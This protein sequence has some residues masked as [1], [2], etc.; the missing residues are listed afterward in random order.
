MCACCCICGD[1]LILLY[2]RH[3]WV[4]STYVAEDS[5]FGYDTVSLSNQIPAFWGNIL[6]SS[7]R[8][9]CPRWLPGRGE[10]ENT[11]RGS[12][13]KSISDVNWQ[14][15]VKKK[16]IKQGLPVYR[17]SVTSDRLSGKVKWPIRDKW[18][19]TESTVMLLE[20]GEINACKGYCSWSRV[21]G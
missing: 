18:R 4:F 8:S 3:S 11:G 5:F 12:L 1:C 13:C 15:M 20:Q 19:G 6:V 9:N 10:N 2:N 14:G 16:D 21:G 17:D 7:S